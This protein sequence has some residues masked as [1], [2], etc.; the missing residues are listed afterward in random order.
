M[1]PVK[2]ILSAFGPYA[3]TTEI[4]FERL[5]GQGLYLIT[6]DTGAGKTTIF[7]AI[8]YALYGEASGDARQADM[9]RSK[10]AQ[11]NVPTYVTFTFDYRGKRYCV[12]RNP[13]YQR[14]KGRGTGY[15]T[16]KAEA[17]LIYPDDR[18]PVTKSKEVTRAVVELIGLDRRQFT[19]IAMIAQG[20]FQKLLLA[21]TEERG[22]IFRQI[23]KTGLYQTLQGKL[24]EVVRIQNEE[25]TE[26]KRS[27]SQYMESIV[28]AQDTPTAEKMRQLCKEKFDGR[29]GE[30]LALLEQLCIEDETILDALDN[31]IRA[32]DRQIEEENQ[33][34]GKI[35]KIRQQQEELVKNQE[36]LEQLVPEMQQVE[37]QYRVAEQNTAACGQ[38][39]LERK[40]Q[41]ENLVL[42]DKLEQ[43][44]KAL[45]TA[46]QS[47]DQKTER[48]QALSEQ[49]QSLET[50]LK[51]D[52]ETLQTLA[53]V[54]EEKARLENSRDQT[55]QQIQLLQR[56]KDSWEQALTRQQETE[57]KIDKEQQRA[58]A[59]AEQL[60]QLQQQTTKLSDKDSLLTE[61][62]K[63]QGTLTEQEALLQQ[64]QKEQHENQNQ[65][66]Q[67]ADT[68]EKL[69][70][71]KFILEEGE[72][73]RKTELEQLKNAGALEIERRHEK[74][75]AQEQLEA[76]AAQ[77]DGLKEAAQGVAESQ[78]ACQKAKIQYDSQQEQQACY[79]D[80]WERIQDADTRSLK[81]AQEQKE[82]SDQKQACKKLTDEI[83]IWEELQT[84]LYTAQEEYQKAAKE[85]EQIGNDY[86]EMERRFLGVQAGLLA[87]DLK[88]GMACPVCGA[89]HHK[90]LAEIPKEAP[91]KEAVEQK[92]EQLTEAEKKAERCSVTASHQKARLLEQG[93]NIYQLEKDIF[94]S[95][96][97][98]TK[99]KQE[100]FTWKEGM[101]V[102]NVVDGCDAQNKTDNAITGRETD[103]ISNLKEKIIQKQQKF[104]TL[105]KELTLQLKTV[106]KEQERKAELDKLI[107]E[108]ETTQAAL[109]ALLQKESQAF[110]AAQGKLDEKRRQWEQMLLELPEA[111]YQDKI[112]CDSQLFLSDVFQQAMSFS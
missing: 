85:K 77:R 32:L 55:Q 73:K 88:E 100:L 21:K 56:Q 80:E 67:I 31:E 94:D 105:E 54:G 4:D 93:Q 5:G 35:H 63:L 20:E 9:F 74:D 71:Q 98:E 27:I 13:E 7:D 29:V 111:L 103:Y 25:Y 68:I 11:D 8:A 110:A 6:G 49:Q 45:V 89:T 44:E 65:L 91:T 66:Q 70:K 78:A 79:R 58:A 76:F 86:R 14:P 26:L 42:F 101:L 69:H 97:K 50:L 53:H 95:E 62:Q 37:E 36:L 10:Y 102:E 83:K 38:L 109:N 39:A 22:N 23:F 108:G 64:V 60:A 15:T 106:K 51:T 34:I 43:I 1:K 24:K 92:K 48:K 99:T 28:C 33:L 90:H 82:L 72:N 87:Q 17:E 96:K 61:T 52:L 19:Q 16:Q 41:Q 57:N 18:A 112:L 40:E 12:K 59:L 81:L 84:E 46:Q 75:T 30:G 3:E 107:K 47:I 104:T 2:L